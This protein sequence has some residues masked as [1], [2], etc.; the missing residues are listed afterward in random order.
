MDKLGRPRYEETT[1]IADFAFRIPINNSYTYLLP[2]SNY[3]S[4]NSDFSKSVLGRGKCLILT[5]EH[6]QEEN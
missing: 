3:E 2:C 6:V 1:C 4:E 5:A